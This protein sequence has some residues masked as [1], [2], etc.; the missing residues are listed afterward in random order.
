ML[1]DLIKFKILI[2]STICLM[3]HIVHDKRSVRG[4]RLLGMHVLLRPT[5]V[6]ARSKAWVCGH[7]LAGI[8]GSNLAEPWIS[9][10]CGCCVVSRG[11]CDGPIPPPGES[12]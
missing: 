11:L 10:C 7:S 9:V 3:I 4:W 6:A 5:K 12:Y 8:A 1:Y 2:T